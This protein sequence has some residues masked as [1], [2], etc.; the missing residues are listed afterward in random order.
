MTTVRKISGPWSVKILDGS[1]AEEGHEYFQL[2]C[3]AQGQINEQ[4]SQCK[5]KMNYS[6]SFPDNTIGNRIIEDGII[7]VIVQTSI[8]EDDRGTVMATASLYQSTIDEEYTEFEILSMSK[9]S[10]EHV[11]PNRN[12]I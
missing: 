11:I 7:T 3:I 5:L 2:F 12:N 6:Q 1:Q 8:G 4:T 10:I 9:P